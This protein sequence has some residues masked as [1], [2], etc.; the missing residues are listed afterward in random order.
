MPF[1]R[2]QCGTCSRERT[3][4]RKV[5]ERNAET[6]C[7]NC[8]RWMALK[9]TATQIAPVHGGGSGSGFTKATL[10]PPD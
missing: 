7:E 3:E 5:S 8:G 2:Y 1:Y 4:I 10:T 6:R 9:I